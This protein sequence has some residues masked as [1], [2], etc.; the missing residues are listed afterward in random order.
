MGELHQYQ[1]VG[2]CL[3]NNYQINLM[4]RCSPTTSVTQCLELCTGSTPLL[5]ANQLH[6]WWPN[7]VVFLC[8]LT[9]IISIQSE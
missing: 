1:L 8:A 6:H 3:L 5:F 9:L 4:K 7:S 2:V